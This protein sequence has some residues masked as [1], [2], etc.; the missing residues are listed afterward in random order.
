MSARGARSVGS[1][2]VTSTFLGE[3][4]A[5]PAAQARFLRERRS[6]G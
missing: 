3:L 1:T 6:D 5:D 2:T 4:A